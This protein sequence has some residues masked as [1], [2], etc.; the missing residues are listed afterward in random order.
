M[1][2]I[3]N[4]VVGSLI[5]SSPLRRYP[6]GETIIYPNETGVYLYVIKSG[7]VTMETISAAGDRKVLYLFGRTSLFPM[8]SFTEKAVTSS[9]QYTTITDTELYVVPYDTFMQTLQQS[10]EGFT[11]YNTML[12]IMLTEVHELL[13]RIS[14]YS[15]SDSNEKLISMLVF[16]LTHHTKKTAGDWRPVEFFVTHQFLA[17]MTGLARETVTIL[18]KE[19]TKDKLIRYRDK[20]IELNYKNLMKRQSIDPTL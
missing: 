20:N 4:P 9:W 13:V 19:F 14:D 10:T 11:V 16:I 12:R 6:K 17:E 7:V 3:N 1:N 5:K 2:I 18:L 8:V 15:K